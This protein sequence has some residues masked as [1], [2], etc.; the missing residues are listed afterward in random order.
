MY[1]QQAIRVIRFTSAT[2]DRDVWTERAGQTRH[3]TSSDLLSSRERLVD[4]TR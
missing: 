1:T 2:E 3:H 4:V